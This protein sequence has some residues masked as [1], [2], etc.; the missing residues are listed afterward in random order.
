M[1]R[2]YIERVSERLAALIR[3]TERRIGFEIDVRADPTRNTVAGEVE[4]ASAR[5]LI[6]D[7]EAFSQE[8]AF[9]ELQHIRRFLVEGAPRLTDTEDDPDWTPERGQ[10]L[11]AIDNA[12]EHLIIVPRELE[13]FPLRSAHWEAVIARMLDQIDAGGTTCAQR[14]E[15][16]HYIWIFLRMVMPESPMLERAR[17]VLSVE[18]MTSA[19]RLHA[20]LAAAVG[21]KREVVR[22]WFDY[23]G[24]DVAMAWLEYLNPQERRSRRVPLAGEA[25]G[26]A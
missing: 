14:R 23:F 7:E 16:G 5:M 21:S 26:A 1:Q 25:D 2:E 19:D 9:H 24:I 12:L 11:V 4:L 22:C 10:R 20:E 6:P 8:A 17:Q 13:Q 3:E 18:E 15:G